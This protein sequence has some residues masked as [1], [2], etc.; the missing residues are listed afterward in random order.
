MDQLYRHLPHPPAGDHDWRAFGA[1]SGCD[2]FG[3]GG[4]TRKAQ[5]A[6]RPRCR[7]TVYGVERNQTV[8]FGAIVFSPL[9]KRLTPRLERVSLLVIERFGLGCL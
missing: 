7:I 2:Q 6:A 5:R 9:R 1:H 4:F 8:H 3:D